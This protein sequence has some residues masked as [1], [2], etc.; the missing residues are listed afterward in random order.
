MGG[1]REANCSVL[2]AIALAEAAAGRPMRLSTREESRAGDHIWWISDTT[3]F[4]KD[5]PGWRLTRGIADM[6]AEIHDETA[7][8][9]AR[10]AATAGA[11]A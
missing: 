4:R 5:C 2:E 8:R 7:G 6:V 1:G 9:L 11:T 3:R 10:E